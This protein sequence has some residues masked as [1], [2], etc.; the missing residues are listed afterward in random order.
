MRVS[1]S[2]WVFVLTSSTAF[3]HAFTTPNSISTPSRLA[4]TIERDETAT[5][6][7]ASFQD[8]QKLTYRDLQRHCKSVGLE[9]VGSTAVLRTRLLGHYGLSRG[10]SKVQDA[11]SQEVEVSYFLPPTCDVVQFLQH[12]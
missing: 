2:A 12:F 10:E 3:T 7:P 4:A 1:K 8:V 6:S 9:A 5:L 11:T